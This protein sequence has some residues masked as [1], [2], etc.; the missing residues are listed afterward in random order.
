MR[1]LIRFLIMTMKYILLVLSFLYLPATVL[2]SDERAWKQIY[3]YIY[4]RNT[5]QFTQRNSLVYL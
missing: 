2:Q 4:Q 5:T 1:T 3:L